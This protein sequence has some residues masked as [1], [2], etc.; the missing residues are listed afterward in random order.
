MVA[1]DGSLRLRRKKEEGETMGSGVAWHQDADR[2]RERE[3]PP[4]GKG[5][6]GTPREER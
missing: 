4:D 2:H 5:I 6:H 3:N 1:T